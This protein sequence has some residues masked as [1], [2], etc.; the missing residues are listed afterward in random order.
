VDGRI[1]V[2]DRFVAMAME[3]ALGVRHMIAGASQV[4]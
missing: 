1:Y 4:F 2:S 3:L